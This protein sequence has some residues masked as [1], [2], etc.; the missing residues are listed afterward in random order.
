M[1]ETAISETMVRDWLAAR[2]TVRGL[3]DPVLDH[4]GYRVDT[5]S[6]T[7][8][9]RWVFPQRCPGLIELG[10]TIAAPRH[11]LKLCGPGDELLAVLPNRWSLQSP[12]YFMIA[13]PTWSDH[14]LPAEYSIAIDGNDAV[15]AVRVLSASGEIAAS[16]HAVQTAQAFVYDRIVT[17]LD[18]RRKGLAS[19]VMCTLRRARR[20]SDL[21]ELVV[22]TEDGRSLY[23]SLGWRVLSPYSTASI[24]G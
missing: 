16:G 5:N 9:A 2:S 4:G 23:E 15:T 6:D 11:F 14:T 19:V 1:V 7:E 21:P 3:P 10:Q 12:R 20:I 13:E 18:H 8:I 17:E 22:A 24:D